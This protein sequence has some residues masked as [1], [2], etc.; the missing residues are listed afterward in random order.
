M[1]ET[2][3][4]LIG[5][6]SAVGEAAFE[7]GYRKGAARPWVLIRSRGCGGM[8]SCR[9]MGEAKRYAENLL[10]HRVIKWTKPEVPR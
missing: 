2:I 5:T 9:S 10:R 6:D 4:K 7:I 1:R 8:E 3:V